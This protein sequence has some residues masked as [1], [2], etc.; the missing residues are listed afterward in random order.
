MPASHA[1][2]APVRGPIVA[3]VLLALM[4]L[5]V[6][7][8]AWSTVILDTARDLVAAQRL[9]EFGEWPLRG[10]VINAMFN[11]GPAWFWVVALLL[12]IARNV[13][14]TMLLIG[15]L[16][17]LKFP[18]AWLLGTRWRDARYGLVFAL[19]LALP[20]WNLAQQVLVT[21]WNLV[22]ATMLAA[23][24]PLLALVRNG[25]PRQWLAYGLLQSL[26]LHAHPA[27]IVLAL[28]LPLVLW[29]RRVQWRGDIAWLVAGVALSLLPF[30]P[31]LVAEARE[32]WPAIA[33]IAQY[34]QHPPP[35]LGLAAYLD[36]ATRGG[37]ALFTAA[38][39]SPGLAPWLLGLYAIVALA[40][41]AGFARAIASGEG[42][43]LAFATLALVAVLLAV[44]MLRPLTPF[45]MLLAWLPLLAAWIALALDFLLR[46][47]RGARSLGAAACISLALL[48]IAA[49]ASL[50]RRASQGTVPL[51]LAAFGDVAA[52]RTPTR[53]ALLPA[54]ELDRLGVE[55]CAHPGT[56]L[57][58]QLA[59]LVDSALTLGSRLQCGTNGD[60]AI[61]GG[62][63]RDG[64]HLLGLVPQVLRASGIAGARWET[65]RTLAPK[66]V[67]AAAGT[68]AVPD[69]SRYPF[70]ERGAGTPSVYAIEFTIDAN[71]RVVVANAFTVYDGARIVGA[72]V[73]GRPATTLHATSDVS[74]F[75][76]DACDG[77][78]DWKVEVET[79][80][81][82][83]LDIVTFAP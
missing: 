54:R 64:R 58:A 65:T 52:P 71:E 12:A 57:H 66:R 10:P 42:R 55:L 6:V 31:M 34:S 25:K 8:Y 33:T 39:A 37:I 29:S 83:R 47:G 61:S 81:P 59:V 14:G 51:P 32:G 21:H 35:G 77:K 7:P 76:C 69:G 80:F 49:P 22:E 44:R 1:Q 20:G 38:I 63:Q 70:R 75:A 28:A 74:V 53:V 40:L 73:N 78:V 5:H 17:A 56:I 45:Y 72:Q 27:T 16:A 62:A 79:G 24:L 23:A 82:D 4:A 11:L 48:A 41:L 67:L 43:S 3:V 46:A 2:A 9:L 19:A 50:L 30:A 15:V 13:A 36:G 26:A 18:L 60:P 68:Q